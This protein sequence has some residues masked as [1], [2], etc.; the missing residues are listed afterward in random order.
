MKVIILGGG[1]HGV[2]I[3]YFLSSR[4]GIQP[5]II[6]Q[7]EIAC[8]ASGKAGGFLARHW[9]N[10]PTIELHEKSYD[11]HKQLAS[12]L[13]I[14][15]FREIST[16][17]VDGSRT[18]SNIPKWLDRKVSSKIMDRDTAQVTPLELTE[19]LVDVAKSFGTQILIDKV[20]GVEV[21]DNAVTG[22]LCKSRGFIEAEKVVV[23]LG[24]WSGMLASF[25]SHY[26]ENYML[27]VA[28]QDWFQIP[29]PMQG[30]KSTSLI[31]K[32]LPEIIREP[33]A[34]FCNEDEYDCHLEL[35]PRPNGELYIC[36]CGG[37]DHIEGD[38]LREGGDCETADKI[39]ANPDRVRAATL[40]LKAMS[41]LGDHTPTIAQACM[42]PCTTDALP[43]MGK[44]PNVS[45][46]YVSAG[47]N[48]WGILWAPVC[49]LAM[50]EL[51]ATNR[52]N[53]IDLAPFDV[54]RFM[55]TDGKRGRKK[56]ALF[57][58]EQW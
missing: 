19:K 11:L 9:G 28:L 47:H 55:R 29:L 32:D 54:K 52:C 5:I 58:G 41:S 49:G 30:I 53:T 42:R 7:T 15:S 43:V 46:G 37:S 16:L 2:S 25:L 14:E 38:R 48:C 35:Y 39:L 56:G 31:Y 1:I 24:P 45:G 27:G 6:E 21:K 12:E 8:A 36:G 3:A 23:A 22:V 51:I 13:H 26:L 57:V 40:A 17:S 44:I 10:G 4:F 33:F 20:V 50:A 34:A 18:G